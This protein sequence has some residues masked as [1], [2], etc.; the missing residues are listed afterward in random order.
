MKTFFIIPGFRQKATDKQFVWLKKFL[1]EKSFKVILVPITWE[2]KV[3]SDYVIEFEDFYNK[4]KGDENYILGFSYG[5]VITF[6]TAQKLQPKKIF[7]CSLSPDF[8]EDL[9]NEKQWILNYIGKKRTIDAITR[10][11]DSIAKNLTVPTIVFYGEKEGKQYPKLKK[12]YCFHNRAGL[13]FRQQAQFP[14]LEL[15][16]A[17]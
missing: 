14:A 10:S 6:I 1:I 11:G 3:M 4:H 8:K 17:D 7:L 9:K 12:H 13:P 2:R 15:K 5:A 16:H